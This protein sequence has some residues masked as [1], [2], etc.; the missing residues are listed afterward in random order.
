MECMFC[1]N[2]NGRIIHGDKYDFDRTIFENESWI[3]YPTIGAYI[4]G[5]VLLVLKRHENCAVFCSEN[6]LK[7]MMRIVSYISQK[8]IEKDK[9]T[10]TY[11]FEHGAVDTSHQLACCINHTHLHVIPSIIDI[12]SAVVNH[13]PTEYEEFSSLLDCYEW[14]KRKNMKS[15]ILY[16]NTNHSKYCVVDSS[17]NVYPSQYLRQITYR[18]LVNDQKQRGWDWRQYPYYQNM[19]ATIRQFIK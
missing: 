19:I 7:Q 1:E 13:F 10:Q 2:E 11:I 12:Y 15:Y 5:Y 14:I 18:M 4:I 16:G 6:E 17:I 3:V 8:Y 9:T